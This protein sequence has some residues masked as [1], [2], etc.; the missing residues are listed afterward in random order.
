MIFGRELESRR[1]ADVVS[2][3]M[4]TTSESLQGSVSFVLASETM[5]V[6]DAL[7]LLELAGLRRARIGVCEKC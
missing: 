5:Y 4:L 2:V 3:A 1:S 7:L 6:R